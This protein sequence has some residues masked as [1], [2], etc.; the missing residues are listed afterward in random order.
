M[1]AE[2]NAQTPSDEVCHPKQ[3]NIIPRECERQC[4]TEEVHGDDEP[5]VY[6]I[7]NILLSHHLGGLLFRIDVAG[8]CNP[9]CT[10]IK[11]LPD[12]VRLWDNLHEQMLQFT[13][14]RF[15]HISHHSKLFGHRTHSIM[16]HFIF[17][18]ACTAQCHIKIFNICVDKT[19]GCLFVWH[20]AYIWICPFKPGAVKAR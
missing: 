19:A 20:Q 16:F 9:F 2:C 5:D 12:P 10:L 17:Q 4:Q 15:K 1:K 11:L 6:L 3:S 7:R 8:E 14:N 13:F 18:P